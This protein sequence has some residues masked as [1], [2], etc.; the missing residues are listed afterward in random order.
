MGTYTTDN[1]TSDY[2]T[3]MSLDAAN[4]S[5]QSHWD[6]NDFGHSTSLKKQ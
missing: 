6:E 4:F 3:T 2:S 5:T 1:F